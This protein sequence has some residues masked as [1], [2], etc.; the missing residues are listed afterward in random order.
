M[1]AL[2]LI[3][4]TVVLVCGNVADAEQLS[5]ADAIVP[6]HVRTAIVRLNDPD[7]RQREAAVDELFSAGLGAVIPLSEAAQNGSAEVSV[8][9]FDVLQRLYRGND[10][11]IFEAVER[12]FQQLKR[13]EN[14][15]VAARA[16]R[17]FETG[18]E[19]R[20]I[21]AI[22]QFERLG[23]IINFAS[24]SERL[25]LSRPR[26]EHVMLTREWSGGD[27][28]LQLLG[29][30]E[31]LRSSYTSLYVIRGTKVSEEAVFNLRSELPF[32]NIQRR[33]PARLGIKSSP[34]SQ[35][36]EGCFISEVDPDSAAERAGLRKN[37]QVV[38]IDGQSVDSFEELI[39]II[40]KKEPGDRVPIFYR[41]N[42]ETQEAIAELLPWTNPKSARSKP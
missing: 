35:R 2:N 32:M 21:R 6:E 17:A 39:D 12:A 18:A 8:R 40:E 19:T 23:G 41:R 29:R 16:E 7:F 13:D 14:L 11:A 36:E 1:R 31:D 33:G 22:A 3:I 15:A 20:Q 28:G 37:D 9:A 27:T 5:P 34:S 30:I 42:G 24:S 38:E 10:E 25:P 4:A 26:I